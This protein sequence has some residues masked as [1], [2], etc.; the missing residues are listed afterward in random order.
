M[1]GDWNADWQWFPAVTYMIR[2]GGPNYNGTKIYLDYIDL[3]ED[4]WLGD[5]E[6]VADHWDDFCDRADKHKTRKEKE[7]GIGT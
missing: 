2:S 3:K 6:V 5:Y 1:A 4:S 7:H